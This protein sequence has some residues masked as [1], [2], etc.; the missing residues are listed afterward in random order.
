MKTPAKNVT[1]ATVSKLEDVIIAATADIECAAEDDMKANRLE[2]ARAKY[3]ILK[4][5]H[6]K[7]PVGG[8]A[9]WC[10]AYKQLIYELTVEITKREAYQAKKSLALAAKAQRNLI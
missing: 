5:M 3:N 4:N 6:S 2:E 9:R 7:S 10:N 1:R 8:S